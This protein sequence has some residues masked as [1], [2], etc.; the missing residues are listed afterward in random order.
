[1]Q[2]LYYCAPVVLIHCGL[3]W[4]SFSSSIKKSLKSGGAGL[5]KR[6]IGHE[7]HTIF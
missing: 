6:I 1:M 3:Y 5:V 2:F 4:L 7:Q